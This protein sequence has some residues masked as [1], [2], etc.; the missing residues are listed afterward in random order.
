MIQWTEKQMTLLRM[1]GLPNYPSV[2][3]YR[4]GGR[5]AQHCVIVHLPSYSSP[6]GVWGDS[7]IPNFNLLNGKKAAL[8]LREL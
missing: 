1:E 4:S 7:Q 6:G 5:A 3:F 2:Q 8:Y